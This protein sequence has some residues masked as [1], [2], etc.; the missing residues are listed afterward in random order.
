MTGFKQ[1]VEFIEPKENIRN[2]SPYMQL[3]TSLKCYL[4]MGNEGLDVQAQHIAGRRKRIWLFLRIMAELVCN[5]E[6]AN[7][8]PGLADCY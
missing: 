7:M 5:T 1:I 2:Q 6:H 4:C 8:F 3:P